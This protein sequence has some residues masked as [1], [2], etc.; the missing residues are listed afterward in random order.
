M[1]QTRAQPVVGED[2]YTA[3]GPLSLQPRVIVSLIPG[4]VDGAK[5]LVLA[6]QQGTGPSKAKWGKDGGKKR[7]KRG[8]EAGNEWVVRQMRGW[9]G[10]CTDS[11]KEEWVNGC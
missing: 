10:W 8:R 2:V 3:S 9:M 6:S 7:R 5:A 11:R 1:V 4:W